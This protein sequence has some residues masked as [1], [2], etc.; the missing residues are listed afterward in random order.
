MDYKTSGVDI[1]AGYKSVELMKEYVK[2]TMRAEVLG[3][4]GGFS[5]AFSLAKIK[6]MEEPVLL[7]GTDG[8]GTKVKLAMVMDKHDTIGIDAVA[9]CVND[10]ACAG[11]EPLFFL[12]YIACGKN[13]PEKIAAIVK[14]VAEGCKQ[15]DAAL[16]GGETA[17]HPGLMPENEYDLAGFAVGVV[18]KDELIT[19]EN[20]KAGDTLIGIAS[21]GVHSN[22]FSLVRK[23]FEMTKESLDTYYDELGTTLGEALLAPTR[24]YVKAL[25][26]VKDAGVMIKG[27]SHI[28]GGGFY[29]NIPRMLPDGARAQV[30]KDSYEVPAIF[31]L[32]AK[33]GDI[34]EHM[35]Y[36]TYNMGVGMCLAIDPADADKTIAAIESA[37]DKAFVLGTVVAGEKGVDLC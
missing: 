29:E 11:G 12:D 17:E 37:G 10:I 31:K 28:T 19:G 15:S 1:E 22:G 36:N 9:M 33:K 8:C 4:L 5:G 13:Y 23:V 30:K 27:C 34:D 26:A 3:G 21:S 7:S 6:E 14:G 16:I 2:E 25:K 24:I 18:E 35:M 20:I 32:L